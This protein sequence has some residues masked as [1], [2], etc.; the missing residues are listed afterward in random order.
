VQAITSTTMTPGRLR[1][2]FLGL[3]I[4]LLRLFMRGLWNANGKSGSVMMNYFR[5]IPVSN[6]I[7]LK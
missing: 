6:T 2:R 1:Y 5:M 3:L 4:H 7:V